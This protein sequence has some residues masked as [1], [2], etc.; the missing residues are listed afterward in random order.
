MWIGSVNT[1]GRCLRDS[2]WRQM[3]SKQRQNLRDQIHNMV[4]IESIVIL[5]SAPEVCKIT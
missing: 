5:V 1:M 2:A 4:A 3:K